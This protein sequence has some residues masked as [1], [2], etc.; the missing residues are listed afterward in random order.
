L[1]VNS[2]KLSMLPLKKIVIICSFLGWFLSTGAQRTYKPASVL[3]NGSW[4]K[5]SVAAEGVYKID[6]PFLSSLGISGPIPSTQIR[7]LGNEG[8]MLPEANGTPRIDDLEELAITVEDGG[9]GLLNAN[10]FILFYSPGPDKWTK[11]SVNKRFIHQKNLYTDKAFY[12]ITIGGTGKRITTQ[13]SPP[14]AFLN[15]ASFD[16]RFF[17]ELDTFNFLSSGKEWFGEEFSSL[18]GRSLTRS[19]SLPLADIVPG[20]ATL[21]SSV[22]GRSVNANSSFNVTVNGQ[23]AQ[24]LLITPVTTGQYDVFATQT[25]KTDNPAINQSSVS[26]NYAYTPGSSNGQG[27]LNWFRFFC[28]RSLTLPTNG[29]LAFRDWNSVN[30]STVQFNLSN[31]DAGTQVWDVTNPFQPVKMA[32][33]LSGNQLRFTNDALRLKEYVAFSSAFLIPKAE[34]R[35]ANQNLHATIQADYLIITAPQFLSQAQR[36]AQFHQQRNNLVSVIATTEQIFNE[37]SGG[38][39][40]PVALRD[41]VKMYFDK[42][43]STWNQK[44]KYLLL[45]GKGSFD[46]KNRITNNTNLVPAYESSSSVEPLSTY[47]SDDFFGFLED[48]ED[49]N[50]SV[51]I[52]TLD[53]GIGRIPARNVDEAKSFIDKLFDYHSSSAFGPWRNTLNFIADDED[54]NLHLQDA[55]V[56]TATVSTTSLLF[57]QQKIYLDA[58]Q[59]ESGSAG[60]RYP[61]ANTVVNSNIYNGTLLWNYSGHGGPQRLA[62][63]VIID[64]NT[65]NNWSNQ[66][67]LPLFITATCDFAPYDNPFSNSLG[68]NLITRAKTGAV[69]LMTTT[70]LV[71]ANSNRIMNNNYLKIAL[72]PDAFG[73][74]KSLGEAVQASKNLTYTTSGDIVNNRKFALLGDPAMTLAFPVLKAQATSINGKSILTQTDTLSALEFATVEGEVRDNAGL[75]QSNFNGTVYLSLFDKIRNINT[76]GNDATSIPVAFTD[77]TNV[78]FKGKASVT[79]GKFSFKFR[80]PKDINFQYGAGKISLYVQDGAT[81]GAGFSTNVIVGGIAP[82]GSA[83]NEGPEIKAFLNDDRFVN[84]SIANAAPVLL[85]NLSDSSGINTGS[86]GIDHDIVATLDNN[87]NQYFILNSFY[88]TDLNS[89][90]KGSVR[91][92]LPSLA[93]GPHSLKI[94]AWDVVNNSS[95]YILNFTVINNEELRIDHVLNYP[96]PFSTRTAFWF[97]HNYPGIDLAARVDIFT[98]NGRRINTIQKTINTPGNR[99]IELDWN[100]RDEW[101]EKIGRGVYI[102]HLSVKAPNGKSAGKWERIVV[103]E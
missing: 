70:R 84:G 25:E 18:P 10:D 86:S 29:Q 64:Q 17:H 33:T 67:R 76:L 95:E 23:L 3:A 58:F 14:S 100:G 92:Q 77:Q 85:L 8:G 101:G 81:D 21:T 51:I 53:I 57:N 9:D 61:Q 60:G 22:A 36:L 59:Q 1:H 34:G 27:W 68:E 52:N 4:Y 26:I 90:Q 49:I 88:E 43:A 94:K 79:A 103:L 91:F 78:L 45:F 72:Q 31:T 5:L 44:G 15:V 74:Y 50:S 38:I 56:L 71:F 11:D 89:Y 24:Q 12:F 54:Q 20:Q 19:F 2:T 99:S 46:Y 30:N 40:D 7:I 66:Y 39:P 16:E 69:A 32:A 35:V 55:E 41:F 87:N 42:Y 83:D 65:V 37:F 48:A 28:R 62:E 96:N 6:A 97:E 98:V 63:E 73:R 82:G 93:P 80:L 13:S 102:Y 47:T 75:L